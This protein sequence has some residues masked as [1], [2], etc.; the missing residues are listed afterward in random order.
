M[1]APPFNK[2]SHTPRQAAPP[3]ETP[4]HAPTS[5]PPSSIKGHAW[6]RL[7]FF[8]CHLSW[9]SKVAHACHLTLLLDMRFSPELSL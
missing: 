1:T 5:Y 9:V 2:I 7:A 8:L 3:P 4:A 6:P